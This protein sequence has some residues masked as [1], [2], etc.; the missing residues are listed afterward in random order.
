[1]AEFERVPPEEATQIANIAGL[2]VELLK[3]RYFDKPAEPF[4]RRGVH[5]KDHGCVTAKFKVHD[6]LAADLRVGVFADPGRE[7]D[8][9][10]RFSNADGLVREDSSKDPTGAINHGSRGMAVK[11]MGVRGTPLVS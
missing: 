3:K 6:A 5:P 8:A 11:L 9:F 4:V 2:M 10:I 7:F 1:M